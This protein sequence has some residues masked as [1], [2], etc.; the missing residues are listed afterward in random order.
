MAKKNKWLQPTPVIDETPDP[1]T[2][3]IKE[4]EEKV[5]IPA[6]IKEKEISHQAPS[7]YYGSKEVMGALQSVPIKLDVESQVYALGDPKLNFLAD[8]LKLDNNDVALIKQYGTEIAARTDVA[9]LLVLSKI[10]E[11][12]DERLPQKS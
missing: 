3:V 1:A 7:T 8:R 6:V 12:L 4:P 10:L 9:L 2:P 11:I 5:V